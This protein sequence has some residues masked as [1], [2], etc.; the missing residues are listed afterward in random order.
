MSSPVIVLGG[1]GHAK[2]L[3]ETLQQQS[4]VV[5]GFT[6]T[7]VQTAGR[8]VLGIPALGTDDDLL[9]RFAPAEVVLVNGVG[10]VGLPDVRTHLYQKFVATGYR[11]LPVIHS[12]AVV[13]P[14]ASVGE[15]TQ[16]LA[17]AV[18]QTEARIGQNVIINTKAS[19]DHDSVIAD[20]V[21]IAPGVTVCG[22]VRIGEG[23]HIGAGA[24]IVQGVEIGRDS[25]VGAGTLV[26]GDVPPGSLIMGVPGRRVIK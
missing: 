26:L 21:H 24:T 19:I 14:T 15:G 16:V 20:H 3:M 22:G 5:L 25:I 7:D 17:G 1:G 10:S 6:S 11:F 18:V 12:S 23:C 13:S 4:Q 8:D 2:V 9:A